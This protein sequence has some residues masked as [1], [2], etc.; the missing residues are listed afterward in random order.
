MIRGGPPAACFP[1]MTAGASSAAAKP[2]AIPRSNRPEKSRGN[3]PGPPEGSPPGSSAAQTATRRRRT[4][5]SPASPAA[6]LFAR[7]LVISCYGLFENI[8]K[9]PHQNA[10][11]IPEKPRP[12]AQIKT[13]AQRAARQGTARARAELTGSEAQKFFRCE[14]G[15]PFPIFRAEKTRAGVKKSPDACR[16]GVKNARGLHGAC[17]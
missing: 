12:R 11:A 8:T 6:G 9:P 17:T 3:A 1:A 7:G 10:R 14:A 13:P 5:A 15:R 4:A 16:A 2:A